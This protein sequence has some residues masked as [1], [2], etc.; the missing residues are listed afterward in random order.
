MP[1]TNTRRNGTRRATTRAEE[2]ANSISHGVGFVAA[3]VAVPVLILTAVRQSDVAGIVGASVFGAVTLLLYLTS[4][5][6]HALRP[7]R[8]KKVFQMLDHAAIF[9]MIAG[10]YTPFMLGVLGGGWGWA[11][12]GAVW[13]LALAGITMKVFVG[14]RFPGVSLAVYLA[15]GWLAILAIKPLWAAIPGWGLFWIGA[16]GISYTVGTVFFLAE[17]VRYAHFVW[18][19]FVLGGSSCHFVAVLFYG[20]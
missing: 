12:L 11:I 20:L 6:Y 1:I 14:M 5:V 8:T 13:T 2:V 4:S 3:A 7:G 10:S 18:H 16:G 17:R 19:L 9:L 15:M